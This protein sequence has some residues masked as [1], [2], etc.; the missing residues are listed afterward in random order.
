[1][2]LS[3]VRFTILQLMLAVAAVGITL[4][5]LKFLVIF[6]NSPFMDGPRDEAEQAPI[7]FAARALP[8]GIILWGLLVL[9]KRLQSRKPGKAD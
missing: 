8:C 3:P 6:L 4:V 2:K 7:L 9:R 5:F 1:M